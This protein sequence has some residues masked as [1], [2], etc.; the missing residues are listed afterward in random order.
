MDELTQKV[1]TQIYDASKYTTDGYAIGVSIGIRS[2]VRKTVCSWLESNGYI[3][4]VDYI[5]QDKVRCQ[6]TERTIN[7]FAEFGEGEN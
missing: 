3:T 7:F 5:G 1:L 4:R 6:I 2:D